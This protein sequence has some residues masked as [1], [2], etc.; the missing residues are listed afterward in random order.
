MPALAAWRKSSYSHEGSNC[1][2]VSAPTS[3]AILI[4]ESDDPDIILT[5]TPAALGVFIRTA[6]S[7]RF[8]HP[9]DQ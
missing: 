7:G 2:Y 6:K 4:R 9:F 8:D 5:T 3:D 1:L